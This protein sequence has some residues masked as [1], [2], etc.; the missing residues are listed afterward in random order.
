MTY[1][2]QV[3]TP[4]V[5]P[6]TAAAMNHIEDGIFAVDTK[7][8]AA[9]TYIGAYDNA[10]VYADGDYVIGPDGLTYQ[11]VVGGTVGVTPAPWNSGQWGIPQPVVN[12]QW[13][14]GVG[15]SAVWS[16]IAAADL[17]LA[18]LPGA[19]LAYAE[20]TVAASIV[21]TSEATANTV[22]TA[23]AFTA[24]GAT[25]V[26]VEFYAPAVSMAANGVSINVVLFQ[27][28]AAIGQIGHH[29]SPS[30]TFVKET[31]G[32]RRLTPA[33]G[34]RTYSVRAWVNTGS[35]NIGGGAGGAGTDV[36][37]FIR[38]RRA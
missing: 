35:G 19:E 6:V 37:I 31:F 26:L 1:V 9:I 29:Y 18:Q 38:V 16:A 36:P 12:G 23:P 34:S 27:D 8:S 13:I 33:A 30:A 2:K 7:P 11:C 10:H 25:A 21:A 24:D 17:P 15:G 4:S 14:K 3:W 5:S 28:G 20:S 32:R 22:V